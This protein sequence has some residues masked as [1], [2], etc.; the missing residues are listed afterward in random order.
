[1]RRR[2]ANERNLRS[3]GPGYRTGGG[4]VNATALLRWAPSALGGYGSARMSGRRDTIVL[5]AA[6]VPRRKRRGDPEPRS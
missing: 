4:D 6:R 2:A 5:A 3:K 1:M